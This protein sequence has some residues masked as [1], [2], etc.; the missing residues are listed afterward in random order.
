MWP[1]VTY[2]PDSWSPS[3]RFN[4]L[5]SPSDVSGDAPVHQS[6]LVNGGNLLAPDFPGMVLSAADSLDTLDWKNTSTQLKITNAVFSVIP[7]NNVGATRLE[8]WYL[9]DFN[10]L[11]AH[12]LSAKYGTMWGETVVYVC[13]HS[14]AAPRGRSIPERSTCQSG[15]S[16]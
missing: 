7:F 2:S 11:L 15:V 8:Y 9:V 13:R 1:V 5:Q 3:R 4:I 12:N 16:Y 6:T 10:S 14:C